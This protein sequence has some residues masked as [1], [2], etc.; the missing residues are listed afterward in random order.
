[1]RLTRP[2]GMEESFEYDGNSNLRAYRDALGQQTDY[3][4][5]ALDRP[6][7]ETYPDTTK[8]EVVYDAAGRPV[9]ITDAMGTVVTQ[10][11][12]AGGRLV[13][14]TVERGGGVVGP[15]VEEY[16]YDGLDRLVLARSGEAG[17]PEAVTVERSYDSLSRL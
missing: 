16:V 17:S 8:R 14:R 3:A 6:R 2:E 1:K 13:R 10:E 11:F 15:A 4:V 7:R 9:S 5:D 12:D